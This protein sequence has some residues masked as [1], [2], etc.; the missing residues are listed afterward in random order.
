MGSILHLHCKDD[1]VCLC[2]RSSAQLGCIFLKD[3]T[4]VMTDL[5]TMSLALE[6]HW[7]SPSLLF[8]IV[9]IICDK[10]TKALAR[11]I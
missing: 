8:C 11:V 3:G 7:P 4:I 1:K 5:L 10:W 2:L 6:K 9:F